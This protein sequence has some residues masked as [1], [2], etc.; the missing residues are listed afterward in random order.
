[1]QEN[2]H[3]F[4][5]TTNGRHFHCIGK[6]SGIDTQSILNHLIG[7]LKMEYTPEGLDE[8]QMELFENQIESWL[9]EYENDLPPTQILE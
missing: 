6:D 9:E 2:S 4:R 7:L 1:V 5:S 3:F 8:K